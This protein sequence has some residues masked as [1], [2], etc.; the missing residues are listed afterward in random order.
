MMNSFNPVIWT[1]FGGIS[2]PY[3]A[4]AG[5]FV[6]YPLMD[7]LNVVSEIRMLIFVVV[8]MLILFFMPEGIAVKLRDM[9]ERECPRCKT[10][11]VASRQSCRNC[12]AGLRLA[13]GVRE[14][15]DRN[16]EGL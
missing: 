8:I 5:T 7:L 14:E 2:A 4:I 13:G 10:R 12:G 9:M 3:G 16:F 15:E 11:N 6:L 1:I